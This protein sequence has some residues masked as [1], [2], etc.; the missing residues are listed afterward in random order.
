MDVRYSYSKCCNPIP[1]DDVIGF[2]SRNGDVKIHRT[3]CNNL[4]YLIKNDNERVVEV[5]WPKATV[6]RFIGVVR[7]IGEDR[8]GLV[9]DITNLI[10][11]SLKTNMKSIN[12]NSDEG[13]FEGTLIVY[14]ED[15][16]HLDRVTKRIMKIPGVKQ[17]YRF[18]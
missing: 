15:T 9:N 13:M 8:V 12:V 1:G 14:V 4:G 5:D 6:A 17:A 18:E 2:L 16:S 11:N 7:I 3:T 10:S